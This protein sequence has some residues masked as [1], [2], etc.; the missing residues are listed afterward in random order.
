M[1]CEIRNNEVKD[2]NDT[3]K[4]KEIFGRICRNGYTGT[5]SI[6]E[7][8]NFQIHLLKNVILVRKIVSLFNIR[9]VQ[10]VHNHHSLRR[11]RSYIA[12]ALRKNEGIKEKIE[13][14]KKKLK[15][16]IYY[17]MCKMKSS[18]DEETANP[19]YYPFL[20]HL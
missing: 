4:K 7:N 11:R 13:T 15:G 20:T 10:D 14:S 12:R 19:L 5:I 8:W 9:S 18:C 2:E 16:F 6:Y 3:L 17:P 1:W